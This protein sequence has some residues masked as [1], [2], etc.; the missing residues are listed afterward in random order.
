M[1]KVIEPLE[2]TNTQMVIVTEPVFG[3]LA[4]ALAHFTD[5]P[6]APP[7][8]AGVNLS[9]LEAK[10][11]LACLAETLHFLHHEAKLVH[12]NVNPCSIVIARDGGWKLSGFEFVSSINEFGGSAAAAAG[13]G[14]LMFEYTS[15]HPSPWEELAQVGLQ[16]AF[17]MWGLG[18]YPH[19][20]TAL[21]ADCCTSW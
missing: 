3:S 15:A 16:A 7:D 6:T 17:L 9:P 18:Q 14:G 8:R 21:A 1:I 4:N 2:E 11:G 10:Y 12:C 20:R 5:V 13:S 19:W